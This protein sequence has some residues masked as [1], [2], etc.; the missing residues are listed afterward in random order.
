[1]EKIIFATSNEG[2]MKEIREIFKCTGYEIVSMKEAGLKLNIE[3]NGKTFTENAIYEAMVDSYYD[4]PIFEAVQ[5]E[6]KAEIK[7]IAKKVRKA[8]CKFTRNIKWYFKKIN[9]GVRLGLLLY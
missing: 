4:G 5:K 8:L 7:D 2:K 6:N 9:G 3:E 1:M